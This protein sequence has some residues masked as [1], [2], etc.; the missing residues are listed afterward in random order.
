MDP[1]GGIGSVPS[2]KG[3]RYFVQITAAIAA[4]AGLLFGFDN[5]R[6]FLLYAGAFA[7]WSLVLFS[8]RPGNQASAA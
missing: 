3:S 4:M 8:F 7:G 6:I 5:V 1:T 2:D